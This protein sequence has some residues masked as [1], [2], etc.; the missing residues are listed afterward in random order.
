MVSTAASISSDAFHCGSPTPHPFILST[1][2]SFNIATTP[3]TD[4]TRRS[5]HTVPPHIDILH[6]RFV[7]CIFLY[8][9]L[10][11]FYACVPHR[12]SRSIRL[13][14]LAN[15]LHTSKLG[16]PHLGPLQAQESIPLVNCLYSRLLDVIV[17]IASFRST[18]AR[19]VSR[20]SSR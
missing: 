10:Y 20:C 19:L 15:D 8:P 12:L 13:H 7:I 18:S 2:I 17:P 9:V 14:A 6:L 4:L 5:V 1:T 3:S 11:L 16:Q